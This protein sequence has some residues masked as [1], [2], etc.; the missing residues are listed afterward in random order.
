MLVQAN[1][2][3]KN[4]LNRT[5]IAI[6]FLDGDLK[7][8]S[9]TPATTEVFNIRP[10][11]VGRP[12]GEITSRLEYAG[13]AMDAQAV[14]HNQ[15]PRMIEVQRQDGHW[16]MMRI[17]PYLTVQNMLSGLVISF[18]D[19]D[20]QKQVVK[21][22][23][24]SNRQLK[25]ALQEETKAQAEKE[26]LLAES[27][28]R[29]NELQ[30]LLDNA[31]VAIWIA[32]DSACATITGNIFANQL[33][34]VPVGGNISK[35]A[36][37][38]ERAVNYKTF[39]GGRELKSEELPAQRAAASGQSVPPYEIELVF[40][41]GRRV[42]MLIGAVPLK[43]AGGKIRGSV[44]I[45]TDISERKKAEAELLRLNRELQAIS[46]S[47]QAI[48]HAEDEQSLLEQI[49]RNMCDVVGYP[50]AWIGAVEQDETKTI[51]LVTACGDNNDY[52]K[53]S[54]ITWADNERGRGPT[55]A[56][57]RTG[58]TEFVQDFAIDAKAQPWR[59]RA[60]ARGF[61][62]SIALPL[63]DEEGR[64]IYVLSMYSS[65]PNGFGPS[66]VRLLEELAEDVAFA[67]RSLRGNQARLEAENALKESEERLRSVLDNS[68]DVI[69]RVNLQTGVFMYVSPAIETLLGYSADEFKNA[70]W[71]ASLDMIH[72]DDLTKVRSVLAILED[73]GRGEAEYR[74]RT[75]SGDYVWVSNHLSVTKDDRGQPLYGDSS[76]RD[77]T[78]R[79]KAG[80]ALRES[81]QSYRSL[82][83][84][85]ID[86]YASCQMYYENGRPTD[87]VFT[88]SQ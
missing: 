20:R 87:F 8:R 51:R 17:L 80:E 3:L 65:E 44:A 57:A 6:I 28:E 59:S 39:S 13:V 23:A 68:R 61:R 55:G 60:L 78:E 52:L 33:F 32:R 10:I 24:E 75:K 37:A 53:E 38:A 4:Y 79:R 71:K 48:V 49:C 14:I 84:N 70:G 83:E 50:M 21:E 63:F 86:G 5:D 69:T 42:D 26:S 66:E 77:V 25:A 2:D 18:L 76:I 58:K 47:S 12:L 73:T 15:A 9:Y 29:L 56:A 64:V 19:I 34:G 27:N 36:A 30:T 43:D 74:L 40:D 31:P 54:R 72:P 35:S 67:I 16:Y 88:G 81:E 7:I 45:G 22:L 1:D 46:L 85:M 62:S 11:D 41:D 82:F